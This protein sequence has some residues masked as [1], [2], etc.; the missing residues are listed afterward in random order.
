MSGKRKSQILAEQYKDVLILQSEGL[1]YVAYD[2]SA[3]VLSDLTG[4]KLVEMESGLLRCSGLASKLEYI[5]QQIEKSEV[6]Y[7]A[8]KKGE[9][10]FS[11]SFPENQFRAYADK[12]H[13]PNDVRRTEAAVVEKTPATKQKNVSKEDIARYQNALKYTQRMCD[14]LNPVTGKAEK[15]LDLEN[16]NVMRYLFYIKSFLEN[17]NIEE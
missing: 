5:V 4:Y 13:L 8:L 10:I 7:I 3:C 16:P 15:M 14:G 11:K 12:E 1:F 2:E 9:T 17:N 6:S